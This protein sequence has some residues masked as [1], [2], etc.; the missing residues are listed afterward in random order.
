MC[1]FDKQKG[2]GR[3]MKKGLTLIVIG[4]VNFILSAI[5]HGSVLRHVSKPSNE[6]STEYT[7]TNIISVTSGLL[8]IGL[9]V[10][11]FLNAFLSLACLVGL[12][13]AISMTISADGSTLMKGCNSTNMPVNARSPVIVNCPFDATRIYDT[14]LALWFTCAT[15]TALEAGLSVWCFIVGLQLRG[16]GPCAQTYIRE[17]LEEEALASGSKMDQDHTTQG[18]RLIAHHS[19]SA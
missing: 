11:S 14:T 6:I 17:Q 13:L 5:V 18:E 7:V 16:I 3:L 9:L 1:D 4:H 12:I 15:F 2:P 8:H 19:A 10:S